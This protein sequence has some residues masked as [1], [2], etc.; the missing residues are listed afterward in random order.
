M[1]PII[2]VRRWNVIRKSDDQTEVSYFS[3]RF[4]KVAVDPQVKALDGKAYDILY[5]GTGELPQLCTT[6]NKSTRT[7][8]NYD[9]FIIIRRRRPSSQS[10]QYSSAG[11]S[12]QR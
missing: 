11:F 10:A 8:F 9:N 5:V 7:A 2:R 12:E 3:Y 6:A 4:T 1:I